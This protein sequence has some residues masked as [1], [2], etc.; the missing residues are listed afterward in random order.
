[1]I[2]RALPF[3]K[4]ALRF[5]LVVPEAGLRDFLFEGF[6]FFAEMRGVKDSSAQARCAA[7]VLRIDIADLPESFLVTLCS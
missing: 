6:Q 4:N 7:S 3:A 5:L 2:F 1:L